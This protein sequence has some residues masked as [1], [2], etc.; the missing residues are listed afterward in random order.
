[1]CAEYN[2][3][4]SLI[5]CEMSLLF[6]LAMVGSTAAAIIA[7]EDVIDAVEKQFS[8]FGQNSIGE[9]DVLT[10]VGYGPVPKVVL[11]TSVVSREAGFANW[12]SN[13]FASSTC[14]VTLLGGRLPIEDLEVI[15]KT[16]ENIRAQRQLVLFL[17]QEPGG[18]SNISAALQSTP[19]NIPWI[20]LRPGDFER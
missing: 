19:L 15:T 11:R 13:P 2:L 7:S 17:S 10:L 12:S 3:S 4:Q 6:L 20:A 16:L 14:L 8:E 9:C 5:R 18:D 1:M